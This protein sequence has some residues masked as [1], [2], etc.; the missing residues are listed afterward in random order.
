LQTSLLTPLMCL[1][2]LASSGCALAKIDEIIAQ[3]DTFG[4]TAASSGDSS[5]TADDDTSTSSGS[6]G[7]SESDGDE[8]STGGGSGEA[9]TT[10]AESSTGEESTTDPS[11]SGGPFCGDGIKQGDE[12]CDDANAVEADGCRSDCTREWFVF[13]TSD[14]QI[15]ATFP[16]IVGADYHCRHRAAKMFLPNSDRYKAWISTSEV[17][18]V[19]RL[20][21]ARGPYKLV[22]GVQV[23][24][25]WDALVSGQLE[26]PIDAS[27]K[28]EWVDDLV[29]TGTLADGTRIPNSEHC[30][31]WTSIGD[32]ELGWYGDSAAKDLTWTFGVETAC[33]GGSRLYCFEQP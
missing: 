19:D 26:N 28:G 9:S 5:T 32:F 3:Y 20:Y 8:S 10:A 2:L 11:T 16:G 22:N 6:T 7:P 12:E 25:N 27:E 33:A 23:A 18:P 17:Q 13:I 29:F 24:A 1:A 4:S 21:H 15:A 14:P 31:D 30:D